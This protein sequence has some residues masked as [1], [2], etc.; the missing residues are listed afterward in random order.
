MGQ[1]RVATHATGCAHGSD[2]PRRAW[3]TPAAALCL[4]AVLTLTALAFAAPVAARVVTP[5][6]V[7]TNV[8]SAERVVIGGDE[9]VTHDL[10]VSGSTVL[11]AGRVEGDLVI[12]GGQVDVEGAVT[13]DLLVAGGTVRVSGPV[14]GDVRIAG[15]QATIAGAVAEDVAF[16]GGSLVIAPAARIG[17]DL[18]LGAGQSDVAGTVAGDVIGSAGTYTRGGQVVGRELVTVGE[19]AAPPAPP[20]VAD[21]VAEQVRRY[22]GIALV[23]ALLV[24]LLPAAAVRRPAAL[25][26]A[27]PLQS[28]AA[29]ALGIAG[30]VAALVVLAVTTVLLAVV[31]GGLT[32]GGLVGVTIVAGLLAAGF[33][34]LA[35]AL[36]VQFVA[37]AL[38]GLVL[39]LFALDRIDGADR[40]GG[41][42]TPERW[43]PV[44]AL[45]LGVLIVVAVAAV[46]VVGP[47]VNLLAVL[48]GL[49]AMVLVGWGQRGGA[50]A[51]EVAAPRAEPLPASP[52]PVSP[53][54]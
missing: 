15:G 16:A 6:S 51:G 44:A 3:P 8:R 50:A 22:A 9:T 49:G 35:F 38:T 34:G 54:A 12:A 24:V 28:L 13:G 25:L 47:V 39:G 42:V 32:L 4:L 27:R 33:V 43:R 29:G 31:F 2:R 1:R 41:A 53:A 18:Y 17:G 45:L 30:F 23:G 52:M 48:L 26:R 7:T 11:H 14:G 10:Y 5:G 40:T 19:P 46:P 37:P 21:R 20:T 36:A